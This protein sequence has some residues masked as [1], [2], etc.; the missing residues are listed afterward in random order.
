MLKITTEL[1]AHETRLRLDGKVA[2]PWVGELERS[3][4]AVTEAAGRPL[5]VLVDLSGVTFVDSEGKTLLSRMCA[6]GADFQTS[7]C[8]L[9]GIIEQIRRV[10]G[11]KG[12]AAAS[13][14]AEGS[15]EPRNG[16]T[17]L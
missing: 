14:P 11:C 12:E 17:K 15:G 8:L 2:G 13:G 16:T 4:R 6:E 3:W 5:R 9:R 1:N 7:G 10:C